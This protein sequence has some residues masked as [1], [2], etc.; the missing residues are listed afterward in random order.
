MKN[1]TTHASAAYNSHQNGV[2]KVAKQVLS[3]V[4]STAR[5]PKVR[6]FWKLEVALFNLEGIRCGAKTDGPIA[7]LARAHD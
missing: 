7:Q 6:I 5:S 2:T 3:G 4:Q 1:C